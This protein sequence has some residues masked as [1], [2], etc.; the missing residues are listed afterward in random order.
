MNYCLDISERLRRRIPSFPACETPWEL[1]RA[2]T[3]S[4]YQ[5]NMPSERFGEGTVYYTGQPRQTEIQPYCVIIGPVILEDGVRI[6][7]FSFIRGPVYLGHNTKVGPHSEIARTIMMDGVILGHKN[8]IID[9]IYC[10]NVMSAFSTNTNVNLQG[11]DIKVHYGEDSSLYDKS[12]G[13]FVGPNSKLGVA[14]ITMPGAYIAEGSRIFGPCVVHG[15]NK[16][17]P[18]IE[19]NR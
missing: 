2:F 11:G 14:T 6:G 18:M 4:E 8:T 1:H 15:N 7:P 5:I 13:A 19:G 10:D 16:I 12:Y 17:K 3:S 9:S